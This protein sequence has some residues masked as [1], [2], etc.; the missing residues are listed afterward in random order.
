MGRSNLHLLKAFVK[1]DVHNKSFSFFTSRKETE[2][3][4]EAAKGT[5]KCRKWHHFS[6]QKHRIWGIVS[7]TMACKMMGLLL[8]VCVQMEDVL[9]VAAAAGECVKWAA[10]S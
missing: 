8:K 1:S 3:V 5:I 7:I 4:G 10:S 9:P 2:G 6:C